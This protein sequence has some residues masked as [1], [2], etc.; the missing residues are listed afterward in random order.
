MSD[1]LEWSVMIPAYEPD[2]AHLKMALESILDQDPGPAKMQ[3][4]VVDDHSERVEIEEL[5]K[6]W[7]FEKRVE[8]FRNSKNMGIGG[9]WN[10]C[11]KLASGELI[12]LM[13]QDDIVRSGFY[14]RAGMALRQSDRVG[15]YL[16]RLIYMLHDGNWYS[17]S[18]LIQSQSGIL[19]DLFGIANN[20]QIAP[21]GFVVRN[22]VY[23]DIGLYNEDLVFVLDE[24]FLFR[25]AAKYDVWYDCEPLTCFRLNKKSQSARLKK[26]GNDL[27]DKFK[28]IKIYQKY[29][30]SDK[31][32]EYEYK[33][34]TG[35]IGQV[36]RRF[37]GGILEEV[38]RNLMRKAAQRVGY[39]EVVKKIAKEFLLKRLGLVNH[40]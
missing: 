38:P 14:D 26:D 23:E 9:G 20:F 30:P 33:L 3:I 2:P 11:V 10:K 22:E 6:K 12:H 40:H 34:V 35:I 36:A 24:E 16:T 28:A 32:E 21:T 5:I 37:Y 13:H 18:R 15:I 27:L 1:N 19:D 7:G 29:F 17:L 4:A 39:Y 8:Y 25:C 31:F